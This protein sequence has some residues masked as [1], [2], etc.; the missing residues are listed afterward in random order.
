MTLYYSSCL[1]GFNEMRGV[2]GVA[3]VKTYWAREKVPPLLNL[4]SEKCRL[5]ATIAFFILGTTTRG[6]NEHKGA[7]G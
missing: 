3:L 5:K 6:R 2:S 4:F 7:P 1:W